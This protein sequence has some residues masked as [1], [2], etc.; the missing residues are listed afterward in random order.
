MKQDTNKYLVIGAS[1]KTGSRVYQKLQEMGFDVKGA[2]RNGEL[3][4]DW[5]APETWAMA[6]LGVDTIYLTY[7]PDLA[8]PQAP[9]DIAKFCALAKI[10]GVKHITLLSGRGEPTAQ[11]C[12]DIVKGSGLSW[13]IVRASWF[14]QNFS[15]GMFRDFIDAGTI[16]LPVVNATEPFIDVD[17]ISE[18]VVASLLD[19][20]HNGQLY[21]V[22]GPELLSFGQLADKFTKVLGRPITFNQVSQDQFITNMQEHDVDPKAI[23]TLTYLFTEVLD[24]R[25][26]YLVDGVERALGRPAKR[27]EDFILDNL[28]AFS[29][30]PA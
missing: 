5:R 11:V 15:E 30:V 9:D 17:D 25:N 2:S 23:E 27:F 8:M 28:Q 21:E 26:E 6:L 19:N 13:T 29:G 12:E 18:V 10:K 14:N 7:Y 22:T 1:G 3:H 24:G 16:A 20:K 4:F